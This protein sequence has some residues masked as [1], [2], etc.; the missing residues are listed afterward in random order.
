MISHLTHTKHCAEA[1][2]GQPLTCN[3]RSNAVVILSRGVEGNETVSPAEGKGQAQPAGC[4][5]QLFAHAVLDSMCGPRSSAGRVTFKKTRHGACQCIRSFGRATDHRASGTTGWVIPAA[6]PW[7]NWPHLCA[8]TSVPV[9]HP[10]RRHQQTDG[11]RTGQ[12][13]SNP[14]P[15]KRLFANIRARLL[16]HNRVAQTGGISTTPWCCPFF[17]QL[18]P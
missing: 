10:V 6:R 17:S 1:G 4:L 16:S 12:S 11:S 8:E 7:L 9:R 18:N 13:R 15:P 5:E 2:I 14:L 3:P